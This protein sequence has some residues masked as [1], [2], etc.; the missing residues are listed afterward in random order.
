MRVLM[1]S[2]AL[3]G[4]LFCAVPALGG[5]WRDLFDGKTTEALMSSSICIFSV[6]I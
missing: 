1:R 4:A 5:E 2:A 3:L 6:A